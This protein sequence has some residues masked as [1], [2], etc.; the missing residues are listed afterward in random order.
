MKGI[1]IIGNGVRVVNDSNIVR[2]PLKSGKK[3]LLQL[4]QKAQ[5]ADYFVLENSK[6][7]KQDSIKNIGST[8][9]RIGMFVA[10]LCK[11]LIPHTNENPNRVMLEI[12][13]KIIR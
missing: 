13:D 5:V 4:S 11:K 8:D 1:E 6:I 7:V 2:V 10:N 9:E 12:F 3:L